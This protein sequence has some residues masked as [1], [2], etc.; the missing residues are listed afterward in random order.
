MEMCDNYVVNGRQ[1]EDMVT[2]SHSFCY[3]EGYRLEYLALSKNVHKS[4]E[5]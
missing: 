3:I 1:M 4:Y 2:Y 5:T